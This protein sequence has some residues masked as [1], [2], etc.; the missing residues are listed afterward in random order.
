MLAEL[1]AL[2]L[3]CISPSGHCDR[4]MVK[5]CDVSLC[6]NSPFITKQ[7]LNEDVVK[8]SWLQ[9]LVVREVV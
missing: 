4:L 1:Y 5:G 8:S 2:R 3:L 7:V 6:K 9:T